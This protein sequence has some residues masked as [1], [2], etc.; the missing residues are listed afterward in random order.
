MRIT[1]PEMSHMMKPPE[2]K[3]PQF[4]FPHQRIAVRTTTATTADVK[5]TRHSSWL[6]HLHSQQIDSMQ[7]LSPQATEMANSHPPVGHHPITLKPSILRTDQR[8]YLGS[9]SISTWHSQ[10]L[11]EL[12]RRNLHNLKLVLMRACESDC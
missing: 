5:K 10:P 8:F 3:C 11:M 12:Q 4:P 6:L 1:H 2:P 7:K 9:R